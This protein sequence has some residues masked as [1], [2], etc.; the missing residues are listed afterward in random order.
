MKVLFFSSSPVV[1]LGSPDLHPPKGRGGDPKVKVIL[2]KISENQH[3]SLDTSHRS[4]MFD[5]L[6]SKGN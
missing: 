4:V 3:L 2:S 1:Q 5:V 6:G